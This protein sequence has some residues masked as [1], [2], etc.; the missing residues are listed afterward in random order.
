MAKEAACRTIH[1]ALLFTQY[2]HETNDI[3]ILP[4]QI[5]LIPYLNPIASFF[6]FKI[7]EIINSISLLLNDSR[8]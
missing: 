5:D 8:L 1:E 3:I 7:V 2:M 4:M 6:T